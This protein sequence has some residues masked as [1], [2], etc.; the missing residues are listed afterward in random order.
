ML[1]EPVEELK[2]FREFKNPIFIPAFWFE[3]RMILPDSLV[4][5]MWLLSNLECILRV[6]GWSV[7]G[8]CVG[9]LVVLGIYYKVAIV[10]ASKR[11]PVFVDYS[12]TSI[13]ENCSTGQA[14]EPNQ[15]DGD[16][17]D[18]PILNQRY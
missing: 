8:L 10:D 5:Q 9:V 18:T 3:T 14:D 12:S 13:V 1:I 7:F 11:G 6:T 17:D 16:E 2:L 15:S 4:S